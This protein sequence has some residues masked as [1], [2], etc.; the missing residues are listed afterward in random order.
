[1]WKLMFKYTHDT[2]MIKKDGELA[3][4]DLDIKI[5]KGDNVRLKKKLEIV[6]DEVDRLMELIDTMKGSRPVRD[7][8][9][10]QYTKATA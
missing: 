4:R 9:N 8:K 3:S 10:G 6:E 5:S 2:I 7:K 1:M